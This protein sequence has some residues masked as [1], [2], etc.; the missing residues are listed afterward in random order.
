M[1]NTEIFD[2]IIEN[3]SKSIINEYL[4]DIT[5]VNTKD[6]KYRYS[7]NLN[8]KEIID[9]LEK[10]LDVISFNISRNLNIKDTK[11]IKIILL[12]QIQSKH[13]RLQ[14][15][16]LSQ[17]FTSSNKLDANDLKKIYYQHLKYHIMNDNVKEKIIALSK[18]DDFKDWLKRRWKIV[19]TGYLAVLA[20]LLITYYVFLNDK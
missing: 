12:Q 13:F 16:K 7:N 20:I 14:V 9:A 18:D 5:I 3:I 10:N 17:E 19:I 4:T 6:K 2:Q 1:S 11:S 15:D 8:S